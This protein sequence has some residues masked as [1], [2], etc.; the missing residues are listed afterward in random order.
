MDAQSRGIDYRKAPLQRPWPFTEFAKTL[1]RL[2]GRKGGLSDF[3]MGE[4]E[5]LRKLYD[6][7][8]ALDQRH[9]ERAVAKAQHKTIPYIAHELNQPT[10]E[11]Q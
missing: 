10:P 9:L 7:H 2:M 1:A 6:R 5:T 11:D 3:T 4:L 8:A